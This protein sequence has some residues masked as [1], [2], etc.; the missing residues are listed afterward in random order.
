M[1]KTAQGLVTYAEAYLG[2]PYWY[3][4]FGQKASKE[5]YESKK[6]QYPKQYTWKYSSNVLNK[7]VFDCVGLIKGYLWSDT[8]TSSPKYNSAQDVSANGML[9]KCTRK[10]KIVDLPEVPG[11]LVFKKGHVG[12]YLG[13]GKVIEAR[14]HSKGIILSDLKELKWTHYGFCPWIT[15]GDVA[16]A[17]TRAAKYYPQYTGKSVSIVDALKSL[18]VDASFAHRKTIAFTNGIKGYLGSPAQNTKLLSL[19]KQGKLVKE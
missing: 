6:K 17:D 10:G 19:L 4:C 9:D 18:G 8:I 15:Y 14:G 5:L 3:G 16:Q 13:K 11:V 7:R 2:N 1:N 12:I